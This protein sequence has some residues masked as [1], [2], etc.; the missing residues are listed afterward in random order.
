MR[1]KGTNTS[2]QYVAMLSAMGAP[3]RLRIMRLLLS[4]HPKGLIAGQIGRELEIPG[5][6]L[7]HHLGKLKNAGLITA[8]RDR[9][10]LWYSVNTESMTG[11]LRFLSLSAAFGLTRITES[12]LLEPHL[13]AMDVQANANER[14]VISNTNFKRCLRASQGQKRTVIRDLLAA[15]RANILRDLAQQS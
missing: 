15:E 12:R 3:P 10:F 2:A 8:R 6:T 14:F 4:A 11:L 1:P 5:A 13:A 9:T 7:S